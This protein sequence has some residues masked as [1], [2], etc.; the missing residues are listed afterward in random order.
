MYQSD[1]LEVKGDGVINM[2][3]KYKGPVYEMENP[4][5]T[6]G[7]SWELPILLPLT[8]EAG[9]TKYAFLI[10]PAPASL[11]DNK[12][13]YFVGDFDVETGKFTPDEKFNNNPA[14][15]DYGC[16]VLTGPSAFVDPVSGDTYL[17]SIMQD[18]RNGA[19]EGAAGWAHCVGL[20]RKVWLNEKGD[21]LCMA[22]ADAL[23]NLEDTVLVDE[24]NLTLKQANE[25]LA[26][27]KGDLLYLKAVVTPKQAAEFGI[28]VKANDKKDRTF[29][30]YNV[31]EEKISGETKNKGK[32]ASTN[33]VSGPLSLQDGKLVLEIYIDRSLVEAFFNDTKSISMRSYNEFESQGIQFFA[34][35]EIDIEELYVATM[36]SIYK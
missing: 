5:L 15:L 28:H 25:A 11:A 4:S 3:W 12:I 10:S 7:T 31:Q 6:Y 19:E 16:N 14:L 18:Q 23:K 34:D 17:F 29:F 22:P 8:N 32:V 9:M 33:R 35:Q 21:D 36:K 26:K 2:D 20:P 30:T 1:T 24:K 27:V 13:Y